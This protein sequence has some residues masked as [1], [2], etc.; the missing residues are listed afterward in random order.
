MIKFAVKGDRGRRVV[1]L[2]LS[3]ENVKRLKAG[4]P[5]HIHLNDLGFPNMECL[6]FYGETEEKMFET[7]K[8]LIG[9]DTQVVTKATLQ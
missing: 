6:I 5:I 4:D 7:Y 2:G 3:R 1:G 8:D 9:P